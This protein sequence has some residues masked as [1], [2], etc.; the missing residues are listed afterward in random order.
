[1]Q[2]LVRALNL[3]Y[4]ATPALHRRDCEAGG[5]EW[6]VADDAAQSVFA[7]LRHDGQ[8]GNA[9]VVVNFTPVP[10][11]GY[12]IGLPSAAHWRV[13]LDTDSREF[14]GSGAGAGTPRV[15]PVASHGHPQSLVLDL[16][17]LATLFL[18]PEAA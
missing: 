7:W 13:V 1:M 11:P 8:G 5:F 2:R 14:G 6:L 3:L 18:L 4:R 17:P 10:R 16:P 15:E 9:L 12:R